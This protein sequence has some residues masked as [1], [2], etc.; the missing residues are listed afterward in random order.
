MR[1]LLSLIALALAVAFLSVAPAF[2]SAKGTDRPFKG[3]G[4]GT[5]AIGFVGGVP[6]NATIDATTQASHLGFATVHVV[7]V[8]TGPT[9]ATSTG[10]FVAANG[11]TVTESGTIT[12]VA[13]N[14]TTITSTA[15]Y[16]ITGGTGR[17]AGASGAETTTA[18]TTLDAPTFLTFHAT[19]TFIGTITY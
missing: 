18:T 5:G 4:S 17:F 3:S 12:S 2:G 19:F 6:A 15:V 10:T 9:T 14:P 11:D 16:T 7:N 1:R 13:V 8:F